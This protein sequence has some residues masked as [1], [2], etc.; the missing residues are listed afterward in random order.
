MVVDVAEVALVLRGHA[1]QLVAAGE[2]CGEHVALR[3]D[4]LPQLHELPLHRD[5]LL[6]RRRLRV[7]EDRVLEL[8]E[9][10]VELGQLRQEAVDELVDDEVE[11]PEPFLV[12]LEALVRLVPEILEDGALSLVHGDQPLLRVEAVHLDRREPGAA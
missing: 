7:G 6:Q 4:D 8:I 5:R 1:R 11:D 3:I 10:V 2:E 12:L 9:L